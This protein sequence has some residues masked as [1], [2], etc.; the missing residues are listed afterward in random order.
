MKPLI[1]T[2]EDI[3]V[4]LDSVDRNAL[5][6]AMQSVGT[7]PFLLQQ[8]FYDLHNGTTS[9]VRVNGR[10]LSIIHHDIWGSTRLL[11]SLSA[12]LPGHT[13]DIREMCL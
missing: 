9:W 8:L 12:F 3:K 4:A 1:V 5:W 2:Y 13:L 11:A 10:S 7:P 6:K